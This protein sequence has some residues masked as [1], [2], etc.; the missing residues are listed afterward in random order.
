MD[1][2]QGRRSGQESGGGGQDWCTNESFPAG[3]L[4]VS[5]Q[6]GRGAEPRKQTHFGKNNLKINL[7]PGLI[8]VA[9]HAVPYCEKVVDMLDIEN[10]RRVMSLVYSAI[11]DQWDNGTILGEP[12]HIDRYLNF[13]G[14]IVRF[15]EEVILWS[16][17]MSRW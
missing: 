4:A 3:G 15:I 11:Y 6:R 17:L 16:S 14:F 12:L 9:R 10:D 2:A 7:K 1:V 8:S 13:S 5:P